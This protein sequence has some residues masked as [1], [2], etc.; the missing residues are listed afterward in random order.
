MDGACGTYVGEEKWLWWGNMNEGDH[1]EDL[2]VHDNR[3]LNWIWKKRE[4][5]A[6]SE[7]IWTRKNKA[8]AVMDNVMN[9]RFR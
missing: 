9:L 8:W 3:I 4:D 2:G 1:L 6:Y 5:E 7:L